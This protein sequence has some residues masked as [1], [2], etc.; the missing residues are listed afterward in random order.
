MF[1]G[2]LNLFPKLIPP[3]YSTEVL[4]KRKGRHCFLLTC[5]SMKVPELR[6]SISVF[7]TL[8]V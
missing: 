1:V 5:L 7:H 2:F 4:P 8:M 3:H 6:M